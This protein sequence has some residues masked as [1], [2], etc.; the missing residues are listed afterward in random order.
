MLKYHCVYS[1]GRNNIFYL[2][3]IHIDLIVINTWKM[4]NVLGN[5]R[6]DILGPNTSAVFALQDKIPTSNC[7]DFR[8]AMN[9]NWYDTA[10]SRAY[11]S[12]ENQRIVQNGIRAGVYQLSKG[13]FVIGPQECDDLQIIMRGVFL[14]NAKN[15]PTDIP[16]QIAK[17]NG[18]VLD[19][20]IPQ[21][22]NDAVSYMKYKRDASTMWT[23]MS[24]PVQADYVNKSLE[25]P[26]WF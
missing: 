21:V 19:Y 3:F 4:T 14:Q 5:G 11:F 15:Q 24:T 20:A 7:S 8:D 9:G 18:I 12:A 2:Q 25:M 10:L 23:P 16:G 1:Q 13:Q 6:V 17:L 22:Y 26:K